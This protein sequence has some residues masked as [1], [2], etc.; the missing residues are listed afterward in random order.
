MVMRGAHSNA[1]TVT[2]PTISMKAVMMRFV[3]A[4]PPSSSCLIARTICGTSTVFS[5]PPAKRM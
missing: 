5:A 1:T 2:A 4:S 3:N